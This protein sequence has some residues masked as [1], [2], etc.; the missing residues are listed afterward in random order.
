ML[1]PSSI[2]SK[3]C[4]SVQM[5]KLAITLL[6]YGFS[7]VA[8]VAWAQTDGDPEQVDS[9]SS[10]ASEPE[11]DD[12]IVVTAQRREEALSTVPLAITAVSGD[13]LSRLGATDT[14]ALGQLAPNVNFANETSRDAVFITIRGISATDNRNEADPTTAFYIDGGYV[15]RLSGA[16]AYFFDVERVEILRGPQGTLYEAT[17]VVFRLPADQVDGAG[18][19]LRWLR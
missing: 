19:R 9:V 15:P 6:F 3:G 2:I 11:I 4:G 10:A 18:K 5:R 16:N 8:I 12:T 7:Q 14:T 1:S 13:A 17:E